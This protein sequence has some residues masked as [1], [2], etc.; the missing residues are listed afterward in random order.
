MENS[1]F[2]LEFEKPL[3]DLEKQLDELKRK[4]MAQNLDLSSEVEAIE[5]KI[6]ATKREIY[7]NLTSWQIIQ[8]ARHPKRPY[9]LDYINTI[10]TD[11]QEF[12][13]D[14]RFG[15]DKALIGGAAFFKGKAIM[16]IAQQKGRD[17]KENLERNFGMP[18]PEGYRKALRLMKMAEKF[19]MPIISLIDTKAAYAGIGSEER[20]VAEAIAVNLREMSRLK[21][22]FISVV[23]GEGSSGGALGIG[24][25]D[26]ILVLQYAYYSICPP[27]ACAAILWRN[28][29]QSVKAAESLKLNAKEL[30]KLGIAD[31]IIEEPYGGAHC[32]HQAAAEIIHTAIGRHLKE[33][34]GK[35][36]D[37]LIEERY[38]KYRAIGEFEEL[39]SSQKSQRKEA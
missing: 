21:V 24:V 32:D 11:F 4:S 28:R 12:H 3:R 8:L 38:Q 5:R 35:S 7:S 17:T 33:L 16:I 6:D 36:A 29:D 34:Q 26:R 39:I 1:Q 22:P 2:T 14:R 10:F 31:E 23:I 20:H 37:K 18:L 27:E 15:D 9:A 25:T 30:V 13:G 19:N